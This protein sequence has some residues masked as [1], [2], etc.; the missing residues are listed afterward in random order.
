[1]LADIQRKIDL[2]EA[3][4]AAIHADIGPKQA[5][6]VAIYDELRPLQE[7]VSREWFEAMGDSP[8]WAQIVKQVD[9]PKS[10][11]GLLN[12]AQKH[13][14]A[15]FDMWH[16]GYYSET[17]EWCIKV[18]VY[19]GHEPSYSKNLAGIKFFA[20]LLTPHKD[21]YVHFGI[22]EHTLSA[23]GGYELLV[24]PDLS[25]SLIKHRYSDNSGFGTVEAALSFIQKNHWYGDS[26]EAED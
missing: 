10:S 4:R 15:R 12:Y 7:L 9:G 23:S 14:E 8:D 18:K 1:M 24:R 5:R 21:G 11:V 26:D 20:G 19:K 17:R 22:F 16:S 2:L 3:E 25:H 13:L 6:L